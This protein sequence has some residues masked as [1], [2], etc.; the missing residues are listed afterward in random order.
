MQA[1]QLLEDYKR[2]LRQPQNIPCHH[3]PFYIIWV[4]KFLIELEENVAEMKDLV[5][6]QRFSVGDAEQ[7]LSRY[8]NIYRKM[9]DLIESRDVLKVRLKEIDD[10]YSW[11]YL[12]RFKLVIKNYPKNKVSHV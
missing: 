9:E 4:E 1:I 8:F 6:K 11:W 5:F 7:F 10:V 2:F 12:K 3:V